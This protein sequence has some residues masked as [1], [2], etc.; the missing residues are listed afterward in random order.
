MDLRDTDLVLLIGCESSAGAVHS[1]T[2]H[3]KKGTGMA[4]GVGMQEARSNEG[5]LMS[6]FPKWG[7]EGLAGLPLAFVIAGAR[8][9]ISSAWTVP[10]QENAHLIDQFLELWLNG[11]QGRDRY[12]AFHLA[13]LA[14]LKQARQTTGSH[15]FHWAGLMYIGWPDDSSTNSLNKS[16]PR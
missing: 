6:S 10:V 8:S 4:P 16:V 13:Q 2:W 14:A 5:N 3:I 7:D 15:P 11:N 12:A 9:I 1:G